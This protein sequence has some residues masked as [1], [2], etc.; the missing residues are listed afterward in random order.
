M[1]SDVVIHIAP[2]RLN[3]ARHVVS[4]FLVHRIGELSSDETIETKLP[5]GNFRNGMSSEKRS[6]FSDGQVLI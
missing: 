2:L 4:Y 5:T 6:R 3:H 1:F